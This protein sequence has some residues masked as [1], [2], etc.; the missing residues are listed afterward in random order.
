MSELNVN[1][2]TYN[3]LKEQARMLDLDIKGNASAE[4]YRAALR[5]AV[6]EDAPAKPAKE[7]KGWVKIYIAEDENDQQ[8][9]FVGVNGKSYR[10]RRGEEVEVP[11]EVVEVLRNAV[12]RVW[13][14]RNQE[15]K[16]VPTYPWSLRS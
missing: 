9:A 12:Q 5:A 2:L 10:I 13:D 4:E 15:W 6:G 16:L 11:P 3:E 14:G 1:Q 7:N 8:P